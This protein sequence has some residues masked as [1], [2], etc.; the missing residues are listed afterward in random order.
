MR[1]TEPVR[2]RKQAS[3]VRPA[4]RQSQRVAGG[5][6][7]TMIPSLAGR[8]STGGPRWGDIEAVEVLLG[9]CDPVG[10]A[11]VACGWLAGALGRLDAESM[12]T[13]IDSWRADAEARRQ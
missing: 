12:A 8:R 10:I 1:P 3:E 7:V 6:P 2:S 11:L 9:N 4:T 5:R 13:I